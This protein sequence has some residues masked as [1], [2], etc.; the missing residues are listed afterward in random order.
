MYGRLSAFVV[1]LMLL[2]ATLAAAQAETGRV[3]G[4]VS[5]PQDAVVPGATITLTSTAT[6]AVR[7]DR[8][9]VV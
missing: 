9:S 4:V 6:G 3:T 7:T 2:V 5:D 1:A 8:K